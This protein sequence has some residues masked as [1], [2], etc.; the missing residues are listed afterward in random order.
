MKNIRKIDKNVKRLYR[1]F[2]ISIGPSC[3]ELK[4]TLE[5]MGYVTR[6]YT[7]EHINKFGKLIPPAYTAEA[8]HS[9]FVLYNDTLSDNDLAIAFAHELGHITLC[10]L[11]RC[12][13][14]DDTSTYQD[15]EADIFAYRFLNYHYINRKHIFYVILLAICF[16]TTITSLCFLSENLHTS[17]NV[18]PYISH[19]QVIITSSG[20]K[21]HH[22]DCHHVKDK[23]NIVTI[24]EPEAIKLQKEP[25]SECID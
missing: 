3:S 12:D 10:H 22:S 2:N 14:P 13:N 18:T 17:S 19:S 25:C 24:T 21:Y 4:L 23:T 1:K 11:H 20:T 9:K 15:Y 8:N 5:K 6:P 7:D 16:C